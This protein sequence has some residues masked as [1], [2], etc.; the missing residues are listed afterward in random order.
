M[1]LPL[2]T[3]FLDSLYSFFDTYG[4]I[5]FALVIYPLVAFLALKNLP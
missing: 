1:E 2:L 4:V 5:V 3:K